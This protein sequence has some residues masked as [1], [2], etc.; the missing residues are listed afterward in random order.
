MQGL[1]QEAP[2]K[3]RRKRSMPTDIKELLHI[4]PPI[5]DF[6]SSEAPWY[7]YPPFSDAQKNSTAAAAASSEP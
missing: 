5:S 7:Q 6:T 2:D 1:T 4:R 3:I